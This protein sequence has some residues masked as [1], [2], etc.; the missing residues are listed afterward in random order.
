MIAWR[1]NRVPVVYSCSGCSSAAQMA[2]FIALRLDRE[3]KAEMSCIAGVG[4]GVPHLVKTAIS[5]RPI[6]ALDG[7]PLACARACLNQCGVEPTA[8]IVLSEHG[9]KKRYH[10]E[11]DQAEAE[12]M[13]A[14]LRPIVAR[15]YSGTGRARA[16]AAKPE[17]A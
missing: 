3:G 2:N 4:G 13:L 5:G 16:C 6:L 11:F 17:A 7:C 1:A 10:A 8:H 9:V 14:R 15:L 12:A